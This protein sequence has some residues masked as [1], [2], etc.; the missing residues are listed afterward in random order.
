MKSPARGSLNDDDLRQ[1]MSILTAMVFETP[2]T[3]ED[4]PGLPEVLDRAFEG[5]RFKSE[6]KWIIVSEIYDKEADWNFVYKKERELA[7]FGPYRFT[8]YFF[9]KVFVL[10]SFQKNTWFTNQSEA[11]VES[12]KILK[13]LG[14]KEA[15]Y[16]DCIDSIIEP[17]IDLTYMEFKR[18]LE[19]EFESGTIDEF[20][21]N[22]CSYTVIEI[23]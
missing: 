11:F 14:C 1:G 10:N 18:N 16:L 8:I 7:I 13:N 12:K 4:L 17:A 5:V 21:N 19:G 2:F 20:G 15:I 22:D 9:E 23:K 6:E 3:V